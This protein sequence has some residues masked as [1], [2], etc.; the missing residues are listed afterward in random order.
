MQRENGRTADSNLQAERLPF[1]VYGTLIPGQPNAHFW[2]D[3]I[4]AE[5][6]A[7][8]PNGRL[9]A[10]PAFPMLIEVGSKEEGGTIHGRLI[11]VDPAAYTQV[12]QRLDQLEEF[13]PEDRG[14][15][16][17]VREARQV[18]T[19]EGTAIN[20]WVYLGQPHLAPPTVIPDGDWVSFSAQ[21]QDSMAEWWLT[22]GVALLLGKTGQS[23]S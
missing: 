13:D 1:F 19:A 8:F 12:L 3:A 7:I 22:N 6:A 11:S 14:N 15:S 16:P 23:E 21:Q 2:E 20:A 18:H 10:F 5:T 17:Y 4:I 9:H